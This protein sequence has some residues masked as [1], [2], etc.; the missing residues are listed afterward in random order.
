MH[1]RF[2]NHA[3]RFVGTKSRLTA[4]ASC[5][6][7][8]GVPLA[9]RATVS[10]VPYAVPVSF[11]PGAAAI[12]KLSHGE[13]TIIAAFQ[14]APGIDGF[15]VEAAHG[16]DGILYTTADGRYVFMGD[17]FGPDGSDLSNSYTRQYLPAAATQQPQ[18]APAAQIGKQLSTVTQ[19]QVGNP[20][21][22]KH[23]VMFIDPNC[24]YCHMTYEALEPYV[25]DGGLR[26][27]IVPVGVIKPS[28]VGRAEAL[29]M[30]K[31]P[32]QALSQDEAQFDVQDEEGGLPEA[33]NPPAKVVAEIT[34]DDAFMQ[35]NNID[36]TPYLLF[37][38]AS[39]AVQ[40]VPGEPQDI[41]TFVAGVK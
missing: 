39:G 29:L 15:G 34:A 35:S 20:K 6:I 28:S 4:M 14:V 36:E 37:R 16:Q 31:D 3:R 18:S 24:I 8:G 5:L 22:P 32:A 13:A 1:N 40:A 11:A 41:K 25:K 38:D 7:L 12:A 17:L 27:S 23:V 30:A 19:F 10:K 33:V 26:L 2:V 9:A 21:A